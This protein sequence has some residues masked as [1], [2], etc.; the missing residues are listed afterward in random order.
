MRLE[1]GDDLSISGRRRGD[2]NGLFSWTVFILFLTLFAVFCWLG[3]YYIF[4]YPE[5]P[6]SYEALRKLRKLENIQK[7]ELTTAPKGEFLDPK[8]LSRRYGAMGP[9]VLDSANA[10]LLRN[11][12][13]NYKE[14]RDLV[15]YV[16][17]TYTILDS[18]DL[19][20]RNLFSSGVVV[21]AQ[22][23]DSPSVLLE[24]V[25]TARQRVVP[26]LQR[27]LLTG[28]NIRLERRFDLSALI[29]AKRTTDGRMLF[30]TLPILYG[31]YSS[32]HGPGSFSL[33]PP[34]F[35]NIR[36]GLPI[37][38]QEEIEAASRTYR[39]HR[40]QSELETS[41]AKSQSF[42][43]KDTPPRTLTS[44][45]TGSSKEGQLIRIERPVPPPEKTAGASL[46]SYSHHSPTF[47]RNV[48]PKKAQ[49]VL[50]IFMQETKMTQA[51]PIQSDAI[52]PTPVVECTHPSKGITSSVSSAQ[53]EDLFLSS[54]STSHVP[55]LPTFSVTTPLTNLSTGSWQ[56]YRAGQMPLGRL[57]DISE[58]QPP[59]KHRLWNE[60]VYLKGGFR[61]T[62]SF[63]NRVVLRP[64]SLRPLSFLNHRCAK[65][66]VIVEFPSHLATPKLGSSLLRGKRRP[67]LIIDIQR[68]PAGTT[69]IFAREV[70][71]D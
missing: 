45:T 20:A 40:R 64:Q 58:L 6:L 16:V 39:L 54:S 1:E 48:Q 11:F 33:S 71:H 36:A 17:G 7:F 41:L 21:L 70:T 32:Y 24:S 67:F 66:R 50:P 68:S 49:T 35:L 26:L 15:P 52:P 30:T 47:P 9:R 56:T 37:L 38:S 14:T 65:V 23:I 57:V 3:S 28:L 62:A 31:S 61:V 22:S 27:T 13:R 25:F 63:H 2:K 18:F 43:K 53:P 51:T 19:S 46:E 8:A 5:K 34:A 29:H 10:R 55:S 44:N 60:R 4:G 59:I 42:H 12:I 69:N